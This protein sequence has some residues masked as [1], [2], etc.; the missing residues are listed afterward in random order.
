MNYIVEV[1][2]KNKTRALAINDQQVLRVILKAENRDVAKHRAEGC[3][4]KTCPRWR[5]AFSL[6]SVVVGEGTA[7]D[8]MDMEIRIDPE[9]AMLPH[10]V[11]DCL[12]VRS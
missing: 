8:Y 11:M 7:G 2:P 9:D 5:R 1:R 6:T 3:W 12:V 10:V 4:V